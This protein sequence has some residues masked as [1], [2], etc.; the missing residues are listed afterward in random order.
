MAIKNIFKKKQWKADYEA[1]R[2][3][4]NAGQFKAAETHLRS[5][6]GKALDLDDSSYGD[7]A[8]LF[9]QTLR[10]LERYDESL[11]MTGK[12][13]RY[14]HGLFGSSD[15]RTVSAHLAMAL[16]EPSLAHEDPEL[17]QATY[18]KAVEQ[19]GVKAWQVVR[20]AALALVHLSSSEREKA[21]GQAQD[22]LSYVLGEGRQELGAWPP[23][24]EEFASELIRLG[25]IDLAARFMA[26]HL[27]VQEERYGDRSEQAALARL[28]LGELFLRGGQWSSAEGALSKSLEQLKLKH[29]PRSDLAKRAVVA[30]GQALA[31]QGRLEQA[32]PYLNDALEKLRDEPGPE[33]LDALV[34]L[35]EYKCLISATDAERGALWRELETAWEADATEA[36]RT[37]IFEGFCAASDRLQESWELAQGDRFLQTVLARVRTW[38]G[39]HHYD[40]ARVLMDLGRCAALREDD[41]KALNF[42]EQS[43]ALDEGPENMIRAIGLYGDLGERERAQRIAKLVQRMLANQEFGVWHG[44]RLTAYAQAL[45]KAGEIELAAEQATSAVEQLP[46]LEQDIARLVLAECE[47]HRGHWSVAERTYKQILPNLTEP[48]TRA[49]AYLQYAWLL[50]QTGRFSE[51]QD[52]LIEVQS[53]SSLRREHPLIIAA[54]AVGAQGAFYSGNVYLGSEE[55]EA[56]LAFLRKG[57]H[58]QT[59]RSLS[60]LTL[61]EP[62]G[63]EEFSMELDVG[64]QILAAS[65]YPE[66]VCTVF[67]VKDVA[68]VGLRHV[69]RA[70]FYHGQKEL[71][72]ER[73]TQYRQRFVYSYGE[74]NTT[75]LSAGYTLTAAQLAETPA[76]RIELLEA[77]RRSLR[78]LG[79]RHVQLF[80]ALS[81]LAEQYIE[82]RS[83]ERAKVTI[84][85]ALA[86][87]KSPKLKE[88]LAT[89]E[90]GDFPSM[91]GV[92]IPSVPTGAETSE[93]PPSTRSAPT[94]NMETSVEPVSEAFSASAE[95]EPQAVESAVPA[96][97]APA[98][99]MEPPNTEDE[100]EVAPPSTIAPLPM[101]VPAPSVAPA[102]ASSGSLED[103]GTLVA[104]AGA[105]GVN[106]IPMAA[107][108]S[109]RDAPPCQEEVETFLQEVQARFGDERVARQDALMMLSLLFPD[110]AEL[111]LRLWNEALAS[112]ASEDFET[113]H[114]FE[115]RARDANSYSLV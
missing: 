89:L 25:Y 30:L 47:V 106:Q 5:A 31:R 78:E 22:A 13:F 84:A 83:S 102:A 108:L 55:R 12:A 37:R 96:L 51:M 44:R 57:Q 29:G 67:P 63:S 85:E 81:L 19:F 15:A 10:R 54:K 11:E 74:L 76:E 62:F 70:L 36:V 34:W 1:G 21:L 77:S 8:L 45:L 18:H 6:L 53:L 113:L 32:A 101:A 40:V 107:E 59:R 115:S 28:T 38:R 43:L 99:Y 112:I 69:S 20:T 24:A 46:D 87:R 7:T 97:E 109:E 9:G 50:C 48:V 71:A 65:R 3:A 86:I 2:E 91:S 64:T 58:L 14:Y 110:G 33:R 103:S 105:T 93:M 75:P 23:V 60:I 61:L 49:R 56:V 82:V 94:Q 95:D 42:I 92:E 26:S 72:Q 80:P 104:Q 27:R 79:G 35:L 68:C 17:R 4:F 100:S 41:A 66:A 73:L 16:A 111:A 98:G 114:H 52:A 39:P 90:Q 88:W